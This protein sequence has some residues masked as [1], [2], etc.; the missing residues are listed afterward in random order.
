MQPSGFALL[1]CVTFSMGGIWSSAANIKSVSDV[2]VIQSIEVTPEQVT[3]HLSSASVYTQAAL[4]KDPAH[5]RTDR[6]YVDVSGVLGHQLKRR[7][8]G[9]SQPVQQVRV[10]QFQPQTVRVVLDLSAAQPCQVKQALNP[11]RLQIIVGRSKREE[12][13]AGPALI[14]ASPPTQ[15]TR[16]EPPAEQPSGQAARQEVAAE[17]NASEGLEYLD[18]R[19]PFSP[20][21]QQANPIS[22]FGQQVSEDKAPQL[23]PSGLY[24]LQDTG[25]K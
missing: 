10:A 12:N 6:C 9:N 21:T 14:P 25:Q 11:D 8:A 23:A 19:T 16:Q 15:A 3:I 22:L 1:L 13:T 17:E 5:Q 18:L 20:G 7:Y 4:P 2:S 24:L